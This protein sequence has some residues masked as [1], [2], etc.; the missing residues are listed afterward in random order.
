MGVH[1]LWLAVFKKLNFLIVVT[2]LF[3]SIF[4][5]SWDKFV[6]RLLLFC[7]P[8]MWRECQFFVVIFCRLEEFLSTN[9]GV[10]IYFAL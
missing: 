2:H 5:F 7:T 4:L 6:P 8:S 9:R 3:P 10:A 1:I